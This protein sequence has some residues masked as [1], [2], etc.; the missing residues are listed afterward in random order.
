M[1]TIHIYNPLMA[2]LHKVD[3]LCGRPLISILF[4]LFVLS[5]ASS[6]DDD[7]NPMESYYIESQGLAI[8][9]RVRTIISTACLP[10]AAS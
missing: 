5:C 8:C 4:T 7:V 9:S 2:L 6:S 1:N 10:F 3:F